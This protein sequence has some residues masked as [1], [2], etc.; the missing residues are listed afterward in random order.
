M[1]PSGA[2]KVYKLLHVVYQGL[3]VTVGYLYHIAQE[4]ALA[5]VL[6]INGNAATSRYVKAF[7]YY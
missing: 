7:T 1:I 2:N 6:V 5:M 3:T 4:N